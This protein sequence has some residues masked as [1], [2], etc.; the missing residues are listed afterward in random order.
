MKDKLQ[1][2]LSRGGKH[3]IRALSRLFFTVKKAYAKNTFSI[4]IYHRVSPNVV[5]DN[6]C[7]NWN[8]H[9]DVFRGQLEHLKK[10]GYPVLPLNEG[11][12]RLSANEPLPQ[13]AVAI[14]F[15]D[16]YRNNY[17]YAYPV[18]KELGFPATIFLATAYMDT[19]KPFPFCTWDAKH[20]HHAPEEVWVP[21]T[22]KDC[23]EMAESGLI[24]FGS[25]THSHHDLADMTAPRFKED[26][27]RSVELIQMH[28]GPAK[29]FAYPFGNRLMG[30]F[31]EASSQA[32]KELGFA[33]ALT[34]EISANKIPCDV[35]L[36]SRLE[37]TNEDDG[38]SLEAKIN[39]YYDWANI[40]KQAF[41]IM[42][43]RMRKEKP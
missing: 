16:G 4:L 27:S 26:V 39:G 30:H 34:G 1:H 31:S 23:K 40:A 43:G 14:T 28:A 6:E 5:E 3:S 10:E 20:A 42:T 33:G 2:A 38:I 8:V 17:L 22:W 11:I 24:A 19:G 21:L 9:P 37:V 32:L 41:V 29:A 15:D 25:H 36:L 7:H 18:L 35:F 12:A 13:R